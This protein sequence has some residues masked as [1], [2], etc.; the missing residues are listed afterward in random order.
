M[1]KKTIRCRILNSITVA[2]AMRAPGDVVDVPVGEVAAAPWCFQPLAE[3][4]S[5]RPP[6]KSLL[7]L[8]PADD[9]PRVQ[10][11]MRDDQAK[12]QLLEDLRRMA[13]SA[14]DNKEL[15]L[16]RVVVYDQLGLPLSRDHLLKQHPDLIQEYPELQQLI[17]G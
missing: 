2:G 14:P 12:A 3:G 10:A 16:L 9:R 1:K 13:R 4:A 11:A 15:I 6:A 5:E 17:T 8:L 7:E